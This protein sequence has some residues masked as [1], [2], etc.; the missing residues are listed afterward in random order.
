[1]II[2]LAGFLKSHNIKYLF[3][4]AFDPLDGWKKGTGYY[5]KSESGENCPVLNRLTN[6]VKEN[7]NFLEQ[8]QIEIGANPEF[9]DDVING[10]FDGHDKTY[11]GTK[12]EYFSDD[13]WHPSVL[14]HKEWSKILYD[15]LN[16][17]YGIK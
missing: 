8:I 9:L 3:F 2:T 16:K 6:Y 14:G 4:N 15:Y 7:V 12:K 17:K 5:S 11:K 1:M 10:N 13:G